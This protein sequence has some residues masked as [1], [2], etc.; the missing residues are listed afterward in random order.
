MIPPE[1]LEW[2][3]LP[4]IALVIAMSQLLKPIVKEF[5]WIKKDPARIIFLPI[6]LGICIGILLE[7][8]SA[9]F[10]LNMAVRRVLVDAFGSAGLFKA[11]KTVAG[12]G[13]GV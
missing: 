2:A 3:D 9:T 13:K 12:K 8:T 5:A 10:E 7:T 11:G 6:I 1:L 4:A